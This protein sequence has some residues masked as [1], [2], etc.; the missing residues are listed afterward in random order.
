M[1]ENTK[2]NKKKEKIKVLLIRIGTIIVG[3]S[4]L[5]AIGSFWQNSLDPRAIVNSFYLTAFI[6]FFIGWMILMSNLNILT[7]LIYGTKTFFLMFLAR[8]PKK[9]Y[10]EY[11]QDIKESPISSKFIWI[12]MI[13]C[14]VNLIVAIIL[15]ITIW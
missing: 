6:W 2:D 3:S 7:P 5:L 12:P 1:I 11:S 8:K 15:N 14:L 10:Y 13:A 4:I 9:S